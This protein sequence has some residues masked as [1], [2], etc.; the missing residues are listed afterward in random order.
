[1]AWRPR[2]LAP[3]P[4]SSG[5]PKKRSCD[6]LGAGFKG[7][8]PDVVKV[9]HG[10]HVLDNFRALLCSD[11]YS[12]VTLLVGEGEER[13]P[14]HRLVL[15]LASRPLRSMMGMDG[16]WPPTSTVRLPADDVATFKRLLEY[17]YTGR[18]ELTPEV[19]LDTLKAAGFYELPELQEKCRFAITKFLRPASAVTAYESALQLEDNALEQRV[20]EYIDRNATAV[21]RSEGFFKLVHVEHVTRLLARDELRA[22][23]IDVFDAAAAWLRVPGRSAHKDAVLQAVRLPRLDASKLHS[24]VRSSKLFTDS[25]I[26]DALDFQRE[27]SATT[28]FRLVASGPGASSSTPDL[29]LD[30]LRHTVGF[31]RTQMQLA[32]S[33]YQMQLL[34][35]SNK[36]I[37][38]LHCELSLAKDGGVRVAD[39]STNGVFVDGQRVEKTLVPLKV[40]SVLS[41]PENGETSLPRYT[42]EPPVGREQQ[43]DIAEEYRPRAADADGSEDSS[44]DEGP[45]PKFRGKPSGVRP[46]TMFSN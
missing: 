1:M 36:K 5:F 2:G 37:S 27:P 10:K 8:P 4:S 28:S 12:D 6:V 13:I 7:P 31:G 41:F 32:P 11:T 22:D 45:P 46:A 34:E 30:H 39:K 24:T 17:I 29:Y 3:F 9:D 23:E 42:L 25:Q 16:N 14:A 35:S 18:L 40:G 21:L 19:V 43:G 33:N 38:S 15:G 20:A 44:E 26:L